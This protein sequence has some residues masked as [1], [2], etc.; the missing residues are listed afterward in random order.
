M[1]I[2]N[3]LQWQ[4]AT[5]E[6]R[7]AEIDTIKAP[8][9]E[10][11]FEFIALR[12]FTMADNQFDIGV[13]FHQK[14][15]MAFHLLPGSDH[16]KVGAAPDYYSKLVTDGSMDLDENDFE[17]K[18]P[19]TITPFLISDY[20]IPEQAWDKYG[21]VKLDRNFGDLHPI[22]S[23]HRD[24]VTNWAEQFGLRLPSEMEWEYACKAGTNSMFYWGDEPDTQYAWTKF[25]TNFNA[26]NYRTL[27]RD[28][29]K[30]PNGFGL[31]GMIGNLPEWVADDAYSYQQQSPSQTAYKSLFGDDDAILRGGWWR[32]GFNFNR[33]TSRIQTGVD[34]GDGCS[35]RLAI[36]LPEVIENGR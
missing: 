3:I 26:D 29:Q 36:S 33:S 25:N 34:G 2:D 20:L 21:G 19:I 13:F 5:P 28:E 30:A 24:N 11:G 18:Y 32:Y 35:A 1:L 12:G 27:T 17:Q 23:I 9:N 15:Q 6:Q 10:L 7:Q 16:F 4:E 8:L 14:L 22:T 31:L